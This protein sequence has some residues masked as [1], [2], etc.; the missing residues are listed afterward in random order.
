[1][2]SIWVIKRSLA[3]KQ[4]GGQVLWFRSWKCIRER[5]DSFMVFILPFC[6]GEFCCDLWINFGLGFV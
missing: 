6:I 4:L 3:Q 5:F 1:M 2:T